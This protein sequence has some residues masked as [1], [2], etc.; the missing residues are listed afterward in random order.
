MIL[1][2]IGGIDNQSIFTNSSE[3][4]IDN[5][6]VSEGTTFTNITN[7]TNLTD[8][9]KPINLSNQIS[10]EKTNNK[11]DV[12]AAEPSQPESLSNNTISETNHHSS[13]N[14][15]NNEGPDV[16]LAN[17]TQNSTDGENRIES[18]EMLNNSTTESKQDLGG[19]KSE[20]KEALQ[21]NNTQNKTEESGFK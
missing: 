7:N 19:D 6:S 8:E 18:E 4:S 10:L 13:L 20:E 1:V 16:V 12:D 5:Q 11:T 17:Q 9:T 21:V 15:T 14:T 3:V 2:T